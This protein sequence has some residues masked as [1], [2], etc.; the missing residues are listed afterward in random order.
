[1]VGIAFD[2]SLALFVNECMCLRIAC[3]HNNTTV[4]PLPGHCKPH[5]RIVAWGMM[6]HG[7]AER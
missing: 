7:R 6:V 1:M 3:S 4:M 2:F 5:Q